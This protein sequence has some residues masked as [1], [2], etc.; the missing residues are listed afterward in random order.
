MIE[1]REIREC[2]RE[3]TIGRKYHTPI[4]TKNRPMRINGEN[5][6]VTTLALDKPMTW[7]EFKGL[8]DSL[9]TTYIVHLVDKYN[10]GVNELCEMLGCARCTLYQRVTKPLSLGELFKTGH[11]MSKDEIIA[12]SEFLNPTEK[13]EKCEDNTSENIE[14]CEETEVVAPT[15][16]SFDVL[17]G[18]FILSGEFNMNKLTTLISALVN[19][20][21]NCMVTVTISRNEWE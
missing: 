4:V 12:W 18:K 21:D 9:K 10:V 3:D 8:S 13:L 20:G 5:G 1:D 2:Y 16:P 17:K 6:D 7:D 11:R 19:E 14:K 15:E